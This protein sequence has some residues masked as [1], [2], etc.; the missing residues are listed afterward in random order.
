V[1]PISGRSIPT[2]DRIGEFGSASWWF[3]LCPETTTE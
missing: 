2:V 1:Y 3:Q